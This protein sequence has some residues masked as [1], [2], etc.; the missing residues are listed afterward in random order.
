MIDRIENLL[1]RQEIVA[2]Q[3]ALRRFPDRCIRRRQDRAIVELP[4][5]VEPVPWS[6]HG[7]WIRDASVRPGGFL[8]YGVADYYIQDAASLLP[9]QLADIQP[10]DW[11]CDACASPGGKATAVA[12]QLG[13]NGLLLANEAIRSRVDV[14]RYALARTGRA[15]YAT[16]NLDP[17]AMQLRC[18]GLFDKVLLDV[19]CSGQTLLSKDKHDD[20]AFSL[21][22][23][24]HCAARGRRIL[25]SA[26]G[27]LRPGGVLIYSTCTFSIE[28]N[29]AQIDWL[30]DKYPGV[31][32]AIDVPE[33]RAWRSPISPGCY[34]LWPHRDRCA[35][36]F[37]AALRLTKEL[38]RDTHPPDVQAS[39]MR[40]RHVER[41]LESASPSASSRS[42]RLL[43]A[44]VEDAMTR[45]GQWPLDWH[46]GNGMIHL[47]EPGLSTWLQT[48][49]KD[50]LPP[51]VSINVG[52]RWEPTH[53]LAML[54]TNLFCAFQDVTFSDDEARRY[55]VGESLPWPT[56]SPWLT[57]SSGEDAS[58]ASSSPWA[59]AR[60]RGKSLGWVKRSVERWNNHLPS[61]AR[62]TKL[63]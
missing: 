1:P 35:G 63:S 44:S 23:I 22:Q 32:E 27:L 24:E 50:F 20:T 56:G 25:Q 40:R 34:R 5:E 53:A 42:K 13:A 15:N 33:L 17:E 49:S 52:K 11:V 8:N 14:L 28:E 6:E 54:D 43:D 47:M 41:R 61:W 18:N 60:W 38:P 7:F 31:W 51:V 37:A 19:P 62:L 3:E 48:R 57:G 4:F 16:C 36:G 39:P 9:I 26:I 2:F 55:L 21:R 29:E 10:S 46:Q 59:I 45:L 12:E 58:Q 30:Q